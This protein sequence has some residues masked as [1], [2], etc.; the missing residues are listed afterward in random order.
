M[1]GHIVLAVRGELDVATTA[2]IRDQIV[3]ILED[4]TVPMIVDLSGVS[5]C[6]ACGLAMLVGAQRR[7]R[8][9][10]LTLA[11]SEPS[12]EV[13]KLLRISGLDH[14]FTIYPTLTAACRGLGRSSRPAVA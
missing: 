1:P 3:G 2:G 10:G 4:A 9:R 13:S 8:L 7:A 5:Y 11:I 6:D 12:D 14:A